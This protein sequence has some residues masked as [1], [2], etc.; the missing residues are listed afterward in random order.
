[1]ALFV[2]EKDAEALRDRFASVCARLR[3]AAASSGRDPKDIALIAVSK[4][5]PAPMLAELAA[6]WHTSGGDKPV[7][8]ESY[9]QE[10]LQKQ[11]DVASLLREKPG[12]AIPEP[13]WHF[14]GHVQR[15]KARDVTGRFTLIHTLD[16]EKL[17][18][19]IQKYVINGNLAPQDVLIQVNIGEEPQKSGVLPADA[20]RL[21]LT[22]AAITELRVRGLMCLPP[23]FD[24]AESSR[25]HFARL[26]KL[27]DALRKNSGLELPRLS[28]GMSHDCEVAVE[29]GA[30]LVR[31]GTDIFGARPP[32]A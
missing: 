4:L 27:R 18:L 28:M 30:T 2:P 11:E 14:V 17:A 13:E 8:G 7:F 6:L 25:P 3:N 31:I 22:A 1:M 19:Q 26:R 20:E 10:A 21:L 16:S 9:V 5:H 12:A 24:N 32:K 29:E 15:R 23:N